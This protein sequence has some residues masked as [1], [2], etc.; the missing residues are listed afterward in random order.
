M[1]T[2]L[3]NVD[4][5]IGYVKETARPYV[6][7]AIDYCNLLPFIESIVE[8]RYYGRLYMH[9]PS[10]L[11]QAYRIPTDVL[12]PTVGYV[13][14]QLNQQLDAVLTDVPKDHWID[15]KV[16]PSGDVYLTDQAPVPTEHTSMAVYWDYVTDIRKRREAGEEPIL[17][18][19]HR[20][21]IINDVEAGDYVPSDIRK[22]AGL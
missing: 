8:E 12:E 22:V 18:P 4:E 1:S 5:L 14:Q 2:Y 15:Y 21:A 10:D 9:R 7:S 11:L 3:V 13:R 16:C 20:L 17:L 19:N 6:G